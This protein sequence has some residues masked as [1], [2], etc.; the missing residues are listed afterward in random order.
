[1]IPRKF[2]TVRKDFSVLI[3]PTD[4][5]IAK[6]D[7]GV[8]EGKFIICK[9]KFIKF[10]YVYY[11]PAGIASLCALALSIISLLYE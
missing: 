10:Y 9:E 1:M 11:H 6:Y 7:Y 8:F 2:Y 5:V 3:S 4:Q